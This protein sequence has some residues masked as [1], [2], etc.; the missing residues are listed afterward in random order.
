[1]V[2]IE[3]EEAESG[4]IE[5]EQR[6]GDETSH[7]E[8]YETSPKQI[9]ETEE[10]DIATEDKKRKSEVINSTEVKKASWLNVK[11]WKTRK[12]TTSRPWN[13]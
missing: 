1:V 5:S 12:G 13:S 7:C 9:K 6:G 10:M 11:Y 4:D 2:D 3:E 8:G